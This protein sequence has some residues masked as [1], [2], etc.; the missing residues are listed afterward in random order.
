[1]LTHK[2]PRVPEGLSTALALNKQLEHS[3]YKTD[4]RMGIGRLLTVYI[5]GCVNMGSSI[6]LWP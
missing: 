6:S 2:G 4:Q 1:M 5:I 3:C